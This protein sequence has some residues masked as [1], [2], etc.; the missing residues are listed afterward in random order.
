MNN[1][2]AEKIGQND[3]LPYKTFF[4][5]SEFLDGLTNACGTAEFFA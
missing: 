2:F 5:M 3:N 1:S 4:K